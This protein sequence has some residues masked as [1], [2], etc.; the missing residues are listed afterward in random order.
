ML[1]FVGKAVAALDDRLDDP[2]VPEQRLRR[3]TWAPVDAQNRGSSGRQSSICRPPAYGNGATSDGSLPRW[4]NSGCAWAVM[5]LPP[6]VA[7]LWDARKASLQTAAAA[8]N[9]LVRSSH[10]A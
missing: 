1:R 2:R 6:V 10:F 5:R 8:V 4:V 7:D 9:L 3:A